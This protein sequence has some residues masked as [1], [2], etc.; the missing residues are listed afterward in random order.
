MNVNDAIETAI[1]HFLETGNYTPSHCDVR[2]L[3]N[4]LTEG[5]QRVRKLGYDQDKAFNRVRKG[6]R[7]R[8][9]ERAPNL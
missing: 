8:R 2:C 4:E 7:Q 9:L 1:D 6:I 3:V 5:N